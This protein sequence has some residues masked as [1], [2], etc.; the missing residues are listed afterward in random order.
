MSV[1]EK[2]IEREK[3]IIRFHIIA[4]SSSQ[5]YIRVK[6][7]SGFHISFVQGQ[8]MKLHLSDMNHSLKLDW[9][10]MAV[11]IFTS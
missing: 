4:F 11:V 7:T 6:L 3:A 8:K 1:T 10:Q 9:T 5:P 2:E